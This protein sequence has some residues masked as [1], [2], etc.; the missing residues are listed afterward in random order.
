M[1]NAFGVEPVFATDPRGVITMGK[2]RLGVG[3]EWLL[4]GRAWR[5]VRQL[6]PDRF[7]AQGESQSVRDKPGIREKS[8]VLCVTTV[9]S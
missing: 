1:Y 8:R 9:K 7:V 4:D 3:T 5:V 6:A 2:L